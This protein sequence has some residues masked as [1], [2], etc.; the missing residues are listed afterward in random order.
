MNRSEIEVGSSLPRSMTESE[1]FYMSNPP[2]VPLNGDKARARDEK[3]P[4][5]DNFEPSPYSVLIGRG[6]ACTEATGNKRLKV[7]VSTFLDEYSQAA[8]SRIEKTII[9]SK[10][11]D[12]VR[13]AT[14]RGAFIK[15]EDGI[16]W[17]VSDHVARERVGSMLRDM[18]HEQYR[19]SSKSKLAK[20]KSQ[21]MEDMKPKKKISSRQSAV[22]MQ[23]PVYASKVSSSSA[24][25]S[26]DSSVDAF[27]ASFPPSD[28]PRSHQMDTTNVA[29]LFDEATRHT[30][31]SQRP[32]INDGV[33]TRI[34]VED[35]LRRNQQNLTGLDTSPGMNHFPTDPMQQPIHFVSG[36]H[37]QHQNPLGMFAQ[38]Q[39]MLELQLQQN[40][41]EQHYLRQRQYEQQQQQQQQQLSAIPSFALESLVIPPRRSVG[42]HPAV[43]SPVRSEEQEGKD[44]S[45]RQ[46]NG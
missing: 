41:Q 39:Q 13:D 12:M 21:S 27:Q 6:K 10:I 17:E 23:P 46:Y 29:T 31:I 25:T 38:Q 28:Q 24:S 20:R 8:E 7:I 33:L 35:V 42:I 36:A 16:W 43:S 14:P 34:D 45:P 30:S 32:S 1:L 26:Q 3:T 40:Q 19:S 18:L 37:P 11:I 22:K 5:P 4:L 2:P 15:Q 9:V 44:K